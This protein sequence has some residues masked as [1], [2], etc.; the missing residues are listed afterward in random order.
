MP[1]FIV[2]DIHIK[3]GK[4]LHAPGEE[5]ELSEEHA[6]ALGGTVVPVPEPSQGKQYAMNAKDTCIKI[7]EL[8]DVQA[9]LDLVKDDDRKTVQD[10]AKARI[11]ELTA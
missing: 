11:T 6:K 2:K 1:K 3:T 10:A 5:V 7:A 8:E 9:I 4:G